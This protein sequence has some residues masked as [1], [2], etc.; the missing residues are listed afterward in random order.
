MNQIW[1]FV[2]SLLVSCIL[3]VYFQHH[4][5]SNDDPLKVSMNTETRLNGWLECQKESGRSCL[6]LNLVR[7]QDGRWVLPLATNERVLGHWSGLMLSEGIGA[8]SNYYYLDTWTCL[9]RLKRKSLIQTKLRRQL[10]W[11]MDWILESGSSA[12]FIP[13]YLSHENFKTQDFDV[14]KQDQILLFSI[15]WKENFFRSFYACLAAY[16]TM[17]MWGAN[18]EKTKLLG[19]NTD[20]TET[21]TLKII[22]NTFKS[23][24]GS[25][26]IPENKSILF[27]TVV[28]GLSR[29]AL[30]DEIHLRHNRPLISEQK[31]A[32]RAFR[33]RFLASKVKV[34]NLAL[35]IGRRS[36]QRRIVNFE[37]LVEGVK[38]LHQF[39]I[40]V[41]YMEDYALSDQIS[42]VQRAK[43]V[44][45]M[46]GAA[47]THILFMSQG[48]YV[49]EIFPFGFKKTVFKDLARL[50]GVNYFYYQVPRPESIRFAT[51]YPNY[52]AQGEVDW[53]CNSGSIQCQAS[54]HWWRNQLIRVHVDEIVKRIMYILPLDAPKYFQENYLLFMP[55]EQLNNQ[56]LGFK[57]A[58]ALAKISNR[59]LAVPPIGFWDHGKSKDDESRRRKFHPKHY[60]WRPF[61]R[62]YRLPDNL[63][64]KVAPWDTITS[65]NP[66]LDKVLLRNLGEAVM[67]CRNQAEWFYSDVGGVSWRMIRNFPHLLPPVHVNE[68]AIVKK[69]LPAMKERV[70]GLGNMFVFWK[71]GEALEYPMTRYQDLTNDE[72]YKAMLIPYHGALIRLAE[73]LL[74]SGKSP[75]KNGIY[76]DAAHIRVGDYRQKCRETG[77]GKLPTRRLLLSCHQ[78]MR[79][80]VK[81]LHLNSD[82]KPPLYVATNGKVSKKQFKRE[83]V[84]LKD[85]LISFRA[86]RP[87]ELKAV[88]LLDK[89]ELAILDQLVCIKAKGIFTGNMYSSFTRTI[90][91]HRKSSDAGLVTEFF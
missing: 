49:L 90:S 83:I 25:W 75:L 53:K 61:E 54:K 34:E 4:Q 20:F 65:L 80:L 48:T 3:L 33:E 79:Y 76:F 13:I 81:R 9:P 15:Q 23:T 71:F 47:L 89:N 88:R 60:T 70:I 32:F 19:V 64:C 55:W 44:I 58:C 40:Q 56:L 18:L 21:K 29:W 51:N 43:L 85:L 39:E 45:S 63:P 86:G 74:S 16:T 82:D 22:Q 87:K 30:L 91:D 24:F 5:Q 11:E 8:P 50:V 69:V 12:K 6:F 84:T 26:E 41:V 52:M 10:Q 57:S 7:T 36:S 59:T 28:L 35:I 38:R 1:A 31:E 46:H 37:Q 78:P 42:L 27:R 72:L 17:K 14:F 77:I 67:A 62:Y 2:W 73:A 66:I 68:E